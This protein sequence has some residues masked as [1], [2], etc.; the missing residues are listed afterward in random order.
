MSD[1]NFSNIQ[2][3]GFDLD[4]T[5]YV[6][7]T[8]IDNAIQKYIYERLALKL[9]ISLKEAEEK[10][11]ELYQ[12]GKGQTGSQTLETLG[13]PKEEARNIVQEALEKADIAQFL[14]PN[15]ELNQLLERLSA[16]YTL[17]LITGSNF[18][19]AMKKLDNLGIRRDLFKNLITDDDG[20]KSDGTV[21]KVWLNKYSELTPEEFLYIGDRPR[22][23]YEIPKNL[24]IRAIL[25]NV[26]ERDQSADC[27]Q[28]PSILEIEKHL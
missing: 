10:F 22:S 23:D 4:Q 21:Y 24:G 7:L 6:K 20:P 5:L 19:I 2:V 9:H 26:K 12:D 17:D 1:T 25:V 28:Y 18:K 13:F 11:K 16:K 14:K 3:I 15:P 27:L 8:E